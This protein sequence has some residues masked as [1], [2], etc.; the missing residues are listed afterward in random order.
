MAARLYTHE[1]GLAA[2]GKDSQC[3]KGESMTGKQIQLKQKLN[4]LEIEYMKAWKLATTEKRVNG[5]ISRSLTRQLK[6]IEKQIDTIDRE[7][8]TR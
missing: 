3:G 1:I 4:R 6:S 7:W 5:Y 8:N 2:A